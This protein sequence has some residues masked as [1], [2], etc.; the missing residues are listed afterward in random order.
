MSSPPARGH[1]IYW[2][3]VALSALALYL[4]SV[5]LLS[6]IVLMPR[7][8]HSIPTVAAVEPGPEP[9]SLMMNQDPPKWLQ[10]Y[11]A[12]YYWLAFHTPLQSLL[13]GYS[14]WCWRM[15]EKM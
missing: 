13:M 14:D 8:E 5:P 11:T 6:G 1:V 12:P 2:A 3:L 9:G 10:T 4:S 7:W 15:L